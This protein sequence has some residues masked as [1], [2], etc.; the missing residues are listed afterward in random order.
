MFF[1][2]IV[3]FINGKLGIKMEYAIGNEYETD[4]LEEDWFWDMQSKSIVMNKVQVKIIKKIM[5]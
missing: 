3:N 5:L 1:I 4:D 2:F